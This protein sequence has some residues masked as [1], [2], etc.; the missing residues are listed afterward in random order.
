MDWLCARLDDNVIIVV[1]AKQIK[2]MTG[3]YIPILCVYQT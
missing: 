2:I 1:D 3:F